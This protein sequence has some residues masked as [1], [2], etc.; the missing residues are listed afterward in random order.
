MSIIAIITI[1]LL[2]LAVILLFFPLILIIYFGLFTAVFLFTLTAA[3][4]LILHQMKIIDLRKQPLL[5]IT[6][7]M[8]F[9]IGYMAERLQIFSIQPLWITQ[10]TTLTGNELFAILI[11]ALILALTV[12]ASRKVEK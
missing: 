2:I 11:L 3:T 9:L 1:I 12:T 5:I 10:P 7:F 6:P 4:L 8:A